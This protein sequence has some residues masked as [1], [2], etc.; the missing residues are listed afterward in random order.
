MHKQI[1]TSVKE[2][3]RGSYLQPN[4][5]DIICLVK[6]VDVHQDSVHALEHVQLLVVRA[7]EWPV[8]RRQNLTSIS[9][10]VF[11]TPNTKKRISTFDRFN[12]QMIL[13]TIDNNVL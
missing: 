4:E 2:L 13:Q 11:Y 3:D 10:F 7:Q 9:S 1:H 6:R 5:L 12:R 8:E